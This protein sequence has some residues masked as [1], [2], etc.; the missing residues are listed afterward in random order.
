M[1]RKLLQLVCQGR[2]F[3]IAKAD[4]MKTCD[5]FDMNP[6]LVDREI[7]EVRTPADGPLFSEFLKCL[8]GENI[9]IARENLA[10]LHL[11]ADE[12]GCR[13]L[14]WRL[15][16]YERSFEFFVGTTQTRL[17]VIEEQ[18]D[19]HEHSVDQIMGEIS[20]LSQLETAIASL[21]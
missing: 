9:P 1:A 10:P 15:N 4:L 18:L 13:Q 5:L 20:Q 21:R 3:P 12:F 17:D 16:T 11:L 14:R 7:Y 8:Q 19:C 6:G 2:S